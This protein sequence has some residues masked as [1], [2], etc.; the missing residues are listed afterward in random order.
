M[1]KM[2]NKKIRFRASGVGALMVGGNEP[3]EKQQD[4][5]KQL[6]AKN[7]GL[8]LHKKTGNPLPMTNKDLDE[9]ETLRAK[10]EAPFELGD[11]AKKFVRKTWLK[12]NFGYHEDLNTLQILKGNL[13]EQD[14]IN[15]VSDV[16][17]IKGFR[18]QNQ[19]HYKNDWFTGTPDIVLEKY[20]IVEDIKTSFNIDTFLEKSDIDFLYWVQGQVYLNLTGFKSFRLLYC[21]VSTPERILRKLAKRALYFY[22][23]GIVTPDS[24]DPDYLAAVDQIQINH[25]YD[26][27]DP[28]QRVKVFEFER[29]DDFLDKLKAR[30][31]GPARDY[32]KS[33]TLNG[34]SPDWKDKINY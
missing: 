16:V 4:R 6:V 18:R 27:I 12:N 19:A 28:A 2:K 31:E 8:V 29:D 34:I 23:D 30:I 7:A 9:L 20:G 3:T 17:P 13:C 10:L 21:L 26:E 14:S 5:F 33:L 32:Y 25:N 15:L 22:S 11:V 24:D 1:K